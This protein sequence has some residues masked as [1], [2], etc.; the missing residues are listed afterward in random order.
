M[1]PSRS[2]IVCG[3]LELADK[4]DN[5]SSK[6]S[7]SVSR[8]TWEHADHMCCTVGRQVVLM[9]RERGPVNSASLPV[10]LVSFRPDS[11]WKAAS[12]LRTAARRRALMRIHDVI[13]KNTAPHGISLRW[14]GP[15]CPFVYRQSPL[16]PHASAPS[17]TI[18]ILAT[19]VHL[20]RERK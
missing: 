17:C 4:G 11:T 2:L 9:V 7:L 16:E 10:W 13:R 1:D 20:T 12:A 15:E 6:C 5:G 18:L 19:R 14:G 8:A 3:H